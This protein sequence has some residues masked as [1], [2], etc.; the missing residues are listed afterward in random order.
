MIKGTSNFKSLVLNKYGITH[1][2]VRGKPWYL[3]EIPT[4]NI[5]ALLGYE[6]RELPRTLLPYTHIVLLEDAA[7]YSPDTLFVTA[8]KER[9][10]T[11]HPKG[12]ETPSWWSRAKYLFDPNTV[13]IIDRSTATEAALFRNNNLTRKQGLWNDRY[14]DAE[15]GWILVRVPSPPTELT[16]PHTEEVDGAVCAAFRAYVPTKTIETRVSEY[17]DRD[18]IDYCLLYYAL[19]I[20]YNIEPPADRLGGKSLRTCF[21]NV[22]RH[23]LGDRYVPEDID[24]VV[25]VLT[26][27]TNYQKD[28][29]TCTSRLLENW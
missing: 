20:K 27:K 15:V 6:L 17:N 18:Y 12:S 28:H 7:S 22:V 11:T 26:T 21:E 2:R 13:S 8:D 19:H 24:R 10:K 3:I 25:E 9:P 14:G 16:V 23:V 4:R 1:K 29:K 5:P